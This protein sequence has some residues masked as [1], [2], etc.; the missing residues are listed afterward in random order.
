MTTV[1][2]A[3]RENNSAIVTLDREVVLAELRRLSARLRLA[4]LELDSAGV[5]LSRGAIEPTD[6]IE[7]LI[8]LDPELDGLL[9]IVPAEMSSVDGEVAA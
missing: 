8:N 2:T 5:A 7:W 1:T 9:D 3:A 4:T 6:A